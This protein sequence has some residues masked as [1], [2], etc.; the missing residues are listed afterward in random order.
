V[1][2]VALDAGGDLVNAQ[3]TPVFY[4]N[5]DVR[6]AMLVG[7][8]ARALQRLGMTQTRRWSATEDGGSGWEAVIGFA[9]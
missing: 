2:V 1:P 7:H 3:G 9:P 5:V 8:V 6:I 4:V